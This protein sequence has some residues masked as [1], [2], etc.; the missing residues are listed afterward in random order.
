MEVLTHQNLSPFIVP[1][2]KLTFHEELLKKNYDLQ[3]S[4]LQSQVTLLNDM[5]GSKDKSL[6]SQAERI[7]ELTKLTKNIPMKTDH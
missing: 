3:I 5:I 2:P 7:D 6:K 4:N 1:P